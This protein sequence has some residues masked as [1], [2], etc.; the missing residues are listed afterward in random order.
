MRHMAKRALS[1]LLALLICFTLFPAT[2]LAEE[3]SIRPAEDG[4]DGGLSRAPAPTEEDEPGT[5][6]G[7]GV[8]DV[9][10]GDPA[11]SAPEPPADE[12]QGIVASG[13]CGEYLTWTLDDAGLLTI[14]GEGEMAYWNWFYTV[15]WYSQRESIREVRIEEGVTSIGQ[16]AFIYCSSLNSVII[17][18]SVT[19]IESSVFYGCSSLQEIRVAEGNRAY[20]SV[21]GVLYDASLQ[22]LLQCPGGKTGELTIPDGVTSI[23]RSAFKG[24]SSLTSVTIPAD[25]TS[26]GDRVFASCGSLQEILVAE[27]NKAYASVDGVLYDAS[28]QTF[29]QCPGGKTGGLTIPS[30]VTVI[31]GWAFMDC[32][33]LTSVTIPASVT[34]IGEQVFYGCRGLQEILVA[35]GNKAYVSVDG[36]LY[37]ASLQSLLQCPG[38]KTGAMT[39]PSSVIGIGDYAFQCCFSLTSVT[40]PASVTSIG[41]LAFNGCTSLKNILFMGNAPEIDNSAFANERTTALYPIDNSTWTPDKLQNYGGDLTWVG[42]RNMAAAFTIHFDPN[43]G[44]GAPKDQIKGYNVDILLP[45]D[46][47]SREDATFLGWSIQ[48][49]AAEPEYQPGDSFGLNADTTLYAVWKP[50]KEIVPTEAVLTLGTVKVCTGQEFTMELSMEKNPGLMYLSFRLDYDADSL[51]FLGAEEGVFTGWTVN[52]EKSTLLWDADGDRAENGVLL[53]LCFR[54][55]E[56]ARTGETAIALADLFATNYAEELLGIGSVPGTVAIL[57]HTPGDVNG[58][59]EVDG[60]D[61]VRLRKYLTGDTGEEAI[62]ANANVNGDD[63]VDILDL[64][65]LRKYLAQEDVFLE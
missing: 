39:I 48:R 41:D 47:P 31:G 40:I 50:D 18:S 1:L 6:V 52:K 7:D 54:A 13:T 21:D 58:D 17:P 51:E 30:G 37:D 29:L 46:V 28:L 5:I 11:A 25:V 4:E 34:S 60:R 36:V 14:S 10:S 9:P 32:G 64:I 20:A 57:P 22:T 53:R 62:E 8:L 3:G 55:K 35:E 63:L 59:G 15:P 45:E 44:S 42:Y 61:L 23:A 65:R 24:C 38:G 43:G 33:S 27:G 16:Q 26:I 49:D 19:S 12:T 2:A 56:E